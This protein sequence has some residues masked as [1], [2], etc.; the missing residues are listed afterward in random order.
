MNQGH[1]VLANPPRGW[2]RVR[3]L[4]AGGD[5][6]SRAAELK[7]P[8]YSGS[9]CFGEGVSALVGGEVRWRWSGEFRIV[10]DLLFHTGQPGAFLPKN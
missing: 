9:V 7:G 6:S 3:T 8:G 4:A 5:D 2:C 1:Q 10:M